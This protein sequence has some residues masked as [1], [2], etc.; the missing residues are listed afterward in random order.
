MRDDGGVLLLFDI[1]GTVLIKAAAAHRDAIYEAIRLTW[2]V[3]DPS[4][5]HIETAGRTDQEIAREI[6]LQLG[7]N[8]HVDDRWDDFRAAAVEAYVARAPADLT[9]HV[10]PGM[11]ALLDELAPAHTLSL[12]TG[13]LE[14][15]ARLK[16]RA[17]DLH[18]FAPGQ[19]AFGSDEEDRTLL[20]PLARLRAAQVAGQ[21]EAWS[22]EDTVV[23]GDTPRDIACAHAD[24]VR[25]IAIPT[26][27]HPREDLH[28]A[29]VIVAHADEIPAALAELER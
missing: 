27:P 17:A 28:K 24:G 12:V 5:A 21:D 6:L 20:P 19:G 3:P 23:I 22:R 16:L 9:E 18:H 11:R 2:G 7:V 10:A 29:D 1:D 15:I 14:P 8:R 13:N 26:G 25:C 4:A